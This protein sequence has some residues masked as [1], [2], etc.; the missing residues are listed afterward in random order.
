[1]V[2]RVCVYVCVSV[3]DYKVMIDGKISLIKDHYQCHNLL[4]THTMHAQT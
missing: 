3:N 2:F 4:N 1:M